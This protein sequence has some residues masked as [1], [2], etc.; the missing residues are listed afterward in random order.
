LQEN[1]DRKSLLNIDLCI[2]QKAFEELE[3]EYENEYET[4]INVVSSGDGGPLPGRLDQSSND[5]F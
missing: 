2:L 3:K 5:V 1:N 4:K